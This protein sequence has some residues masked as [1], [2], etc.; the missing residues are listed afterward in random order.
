MLNISKYEGMK[1]KALRFIFALLHFYLFCFLFAPVNTQFLWK[2]MKWQLLSAYRSVTS[3]VG[4]RK[5]V[6][7]P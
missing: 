6:S 5:Y 1:A 3:F 4:V 7:F 2:N